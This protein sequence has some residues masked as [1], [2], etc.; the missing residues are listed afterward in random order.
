MVKTWNLIFSEI[1]YILYTMANLNLHQQTT[2]TALRV[3]GGKM[4]I[5]Y[6]EPRTDELFD[7]LIEVNTSAIEPTPG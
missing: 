6:H 4:N 5:V 1:Y 3:A 7:K 2:G